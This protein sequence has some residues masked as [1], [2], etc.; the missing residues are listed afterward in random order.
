MPSSD[1]TVPGGRYIVGGQVDPDTGTRTG[2][3]VRDGT[4]RILVEFDV[5]EENTGLPESIDV[6]P[7]GISSND[8]TQ[9]VQ[10]TSSE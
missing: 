4:G 5:D 3:S 10:V 6:T 1:E 8:Q 9:G 7:D 2:G